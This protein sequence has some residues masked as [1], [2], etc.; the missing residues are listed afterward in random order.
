M[1][2]GISTEQ[3]AQGRELVRAA[4]SGDPWARDPMIAAHVPLVY[5]VVGRAL[6]GHHDVDGLVQETMLR[7]LDGLGGLRDPDEFRPWLVAIAVGGV[8]THMQRSQLLGDADGLP[9][10]GRTSRT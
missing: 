5:N 3:A 9:C 8:R 7:A 1:N 4:M 10:P 2:Q 6:N